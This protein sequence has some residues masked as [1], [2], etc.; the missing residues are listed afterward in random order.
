MRGG[1]FLWNEMHVHI[2]DQL[3]DIKE[4]A[5]GAVLRKKETAKH[6]ARNTEARD[7]Y[8]TNGTK[9]W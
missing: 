8:T 9:T 6:F 7:M 2:L 5:D 4:A 3:P 1:G